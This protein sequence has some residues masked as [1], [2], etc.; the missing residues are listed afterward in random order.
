MY[1]KKF[2]SVL[3]LLSLIS[4]Y[5]F[6]EKGS[7]VNLAKELAQQTIIV[8]GTVTSEDNEPLPGVTIVIKG[9]TKGVISDIDGNYS[10]DI[11]Q[12]GILIFS[13]LGM[14]RQE[15][16]VEGKTIIDVILKELRNELDEVTV[17]AFAKQK[18]ESVISSITTIKP[19]ELKVPSSNLTTALSGR[20]AGLISYQTSGE[21]GRDNAQFFIRGVTTFGYKK[22]PLILV[23]NIELTSDDL[24]RLNVD[25]IA[26]FSIMKDAT[27]TSLYGARGANGVIL[28]TTKEGKEGAA[29]VSVRLENS[30]STP[31]KMVS[32]ADPITYMRL[33]N[34]AVRTR[35][36]LGVIPYSQEKIDRTIAGDNPYVYPSV[37]WYNDLFKEQAVNQRVNFN[38]SGGGKV[39]RYYIAASYT[40]D[41]GVIKMDKQNNF[42]SGI[43][44][45]KYYVR[46]NINI[47]LTPTTEA[48][49]R[50][51]GTFDDYR[52][53][54]DGGDEVFKK[55]M[56]ANP[57]LFPKY[58][59]KDGDYASST[60]ILFGN[61]DD[62]SYT[63]PYADMVRGYKE[64]N[65]TLIVAQ[66]EVKQ[67]LDMLTKGLSARGLVSTTRYSYNDVTRGSKPFY[68]R[69]G[70]YNKV[71]DTYSLYA[72]N[73]S[74]G[75]ENLSYSEGLKDVQTTNYMELSAAYNREFG[76]HG[77]SGMLV[78]TRQERRVSNAGDLQKSL[79]Y[80]NQ[81]LSGRFTYAFAKK[82]FGEFNFGYNGSE[83]FSKNERYG[84]F[85]SIGV[86]YIISNEKFFEPLSRYVTKLKLKYTYGLVGND[87]IGDENDRFFYLSNVN[88][89]DPGK[90][91][92]FGNNYGFRPDGITVTRYANNLITWETAK[93]S[94]Y[95]IELGLFDDLEI[96]VDIFKEN[97]EDILMERSHIP[98]S[99]GLSATVK[100]N[101]GEATSKGVDLSVDY[102]F[103]SNKDF[104]LTG[105]ANFTY[106]TSEFKVVEEPDY[107]S[108]GTSWRSRVGQS[109]NQTWG[110]IA[111]RLFIDEADIA[112]SPDQTG[113][114]FYEAGDIKYKDI[115]KDGKIT[116]VDMVPI[117]YPTSPEISYGFGI[118]SGYKNLDFSIF[119][120]GNSNVSFWIDPRA[121]SPFIDTDGDGLVRSEN[122]LMKVIAN[123]H[124][125]ESNRDSYA[126]WPRLANRTMENNYKS[127]TWWMRDGSFMRLKSLEIGYSFPKKMLKKMRINDARIYLSGSNLLTFSKFK[128]WD[129]EMGS[130]GLGYPIQRVYNIGLTL[131]F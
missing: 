97:R 7:S 85:P 29:K 12:D 36:P 87:A 101:V 112:N 91:Q 107:H 65:R 103:I 14:E 90:L 110:F 126:F 31:T 104:W 121:I 66:G 108:L 32:L 106:A 17:V 67:N 28:V 6:A 119:F 35:N 52:G 82:Y 58:Y 100:S 26:S 46:S 54:I 95:G 43:D 38:I 99:M 61:Y 10:I 30:I 102:S 53:P 59:P 18:K 1:K 44:L 20:I 47:N 48:S 24:A 55:V 130:N 9:T 15:V 39:A 117:G 3:I 40:K 11:P 70:S 81:G 123:D 2:F 79:P 96:Q 120:Q 124:W 74:D 84:F 76:D 111:E 98:T 128:L 86:G 13:F 73:P 4:S 57:V 45:Q 122:A 19:D 89:N 105:R 88:T 115:N 21:P 49:I 41:N 56:R 34:E 127:S 114:G 77:V 16:S 94:N 92:I 25:D 131:N 23:D 72:I 33:G 8:K 27:A 93:K 68:Y 22:D 116:D 125:S 62:G 5:V 83:R 64:S 113:L 60:H 118:S 42:N 71:D 80:R 63:N 50:F 69:I 37:D 129:P 109:L 78:F 75:E 51:Q